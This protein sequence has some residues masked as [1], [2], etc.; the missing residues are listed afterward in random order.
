MSQHQSNTFISPQEAPYGHLSSLNGLDLH[1]LAA[2][3]QIPAQS[4]ATL[5]AAGL[6]RSSAKSGIPMPLVDQRNLFSFDNSKLRF[7]EGQSQHIHSGKQMNLLHGIPTNMEPKQLVNLHQSAQSLRGM[8]VQVGGHVGHSS[9][10]SSSILMQMAQPQGRGQIMNDS[11]GGQVQRLP[12]TTAGQSIMSNGISGGVLARNGVSENGRGTNYNQVTQT[13]SMLNFPLNHPPE[14]LGNSF[15]LGSTPAIST[16][17]SKGGFR[18]DSRSEIKESTE[19]MPSYDIF[20]DLQQHKPNGWELSNIGLTFDAAPQ[21]STNLQ[22]S[23]NVAPSVLINQTYSS[24]QRSQNSSGTVTSKQIFSAGEGTDH[25]NGQNIN[26]H[27]NNL[28]ENSMRIKTE[29][30][31]DTSFQPSIFSQQYGQDD[32]MSALLKQVCFLVPKLSINL[33]FID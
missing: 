25:G 1:S 22:S 4:L 26:Q 2:S 16:L 32:L 5:Q 13:S 7:G 24:S 14:L 11:A 9:Q 19:F 17:P 6:S 23:I 15:P 31:P 29:R 8:N 28:G 30:V 27:L 3:G 20:N 21:H 33:S 12:T 10:Q 18:E